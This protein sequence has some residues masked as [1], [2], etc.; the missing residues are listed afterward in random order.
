M[1]WVQKDTLRTKQADKYKSAI[2]RSLA[3]FFEAML[4]S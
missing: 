4:L 3:S 2:D 1:M